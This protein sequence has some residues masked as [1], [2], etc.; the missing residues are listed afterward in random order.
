MRR[1]LIM[2]LCL[3]SM[4][5]LVFRSATPAPAQA[6]PA[7]R[8]LEAKKAKLAAAKEWHEVMAKM[9]AQGLRTGGFEERVT[10]SRRWME[11]E[12]D[13][14]PEAAGRRAAAEGHLG[15][16]KPLLTA[17]E[18]MLQAGEMQYAD[19]VTLRYH[20]A[21]AEDALAGAQ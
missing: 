4:T 5:W 14:A 2:S 12:R 9:Q 17:A 19:V 18:Q 13:L 1:C 10:W 21:D 8:A 3:A 11:A 15:R 16:V 20:L 6:E 7:D